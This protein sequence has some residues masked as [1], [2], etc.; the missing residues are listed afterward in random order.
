[1]AGFLTGRSTAYTLYDAY[2]KRFSES[3]MRG[4]PTKRV[5]NVY[6]LLPHV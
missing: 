6:Q 3:Q 5:G 2:Q 1:M 4:L